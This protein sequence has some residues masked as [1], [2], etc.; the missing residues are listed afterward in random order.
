MRSERGTV[1]IVDDEPR[2]AGM[3]ATMLENHH[4]VWT[5]ASGEEALDSLTAEVDIMLLDRRMPGISGD[6]VLETVRDEGYDCRVAMVTSVEPDVEIAELP[7]DAY[8][9]K[10][11]R[12]RDLHELVDDLLLRARYDSD[13]QEL[14]SMASK[15]AALEAQLDEDE[16]ASHTEYRELCTRQEH[17]ESA[18]RKRIDDLAERGDTGLV[19]RDVLGEAQGQAHE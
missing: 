10:P 19:F 6:D 2:L 9:L 7:F 17:L 15:R 16:L 12:E 8:L 1:L 14:L 5:A 4:T 13:I 11:V 18:S 3:Y